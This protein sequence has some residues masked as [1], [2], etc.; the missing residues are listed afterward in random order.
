MAKSK[1]IGILLYGVTI[2]LI[3]WVLDS[4][5]VIRGGLLMGTILLYQMFSKKMKENK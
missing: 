5:P 2:I 1:L 4:P 3:V